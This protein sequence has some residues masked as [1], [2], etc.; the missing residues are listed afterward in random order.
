[1]QLTGSPG[2]NPRLQGSRIGGKER[3]REKKKCA[4]ALLMGL[5]LD[6]QAAA[7]WRL[8]YSTPP[9]CLAVLLGLL[10]YTADKR[11]HLV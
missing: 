4:S 8:Q 5:A 9:P 1:M 11:P 10:A 6:K 3:E 2:A 7:P